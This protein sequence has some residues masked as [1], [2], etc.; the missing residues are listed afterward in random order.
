M[1]GRGPFPVEATDEGLA[2]FLM[3]LRARGISDV[4]VLRALEGVPR[5]AFAPPRYAD[6]S[7]R[8]VA[9][10]LACGQTLPAPLQAAAI[11][12][13][14]APR[15]GLRA[16]EI[17]AGSGYVSALLAGAGLAV[18]ALERWR[19]LA[20]EAEARLLALGF[21]AVKVA[22]ADGLAEA[23]RLGQFDRVVVDGRM[24]DPDRFRRCL[25]KGGLLV[26]GTAETGGARLM[27]FR[28]SGGA[29][30]DLGPAR[31]GP[32]LAGVAQGR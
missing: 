18:V 14:A 17:G 12:Q 23:D 15:P 20:V 28:A 26:G 4:S 5:R 32:L 22:W 21:A 30:E 10:P 24:D 8:D 9:L 13:A 2:S 27:R 25:S 1:S 31:F 6:L 7:L 29:G 19:T 11:A 16:I 3:G